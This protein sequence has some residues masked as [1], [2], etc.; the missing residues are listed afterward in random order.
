MLK[1]D[2]YML[3]SVIFISC[4]YDNYVIN[5]LG[6]NQCIFQWLYVNQCFFLKKNIKKKKK[7][8]KEKKENKKKTQKEF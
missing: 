2:G 7:T 6:V 4:I 1:S 5:A 3:T 8:H